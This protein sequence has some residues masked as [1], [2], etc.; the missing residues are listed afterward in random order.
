MAAVGAQL[1]T[2]LYYLN[3]NEELTWKLI[4]K[5]FERVKAFCIR[6]ETDTEPETFVKQLGT[7]IGQM[8][9]D[10]FML[11]QIRGEGEEIEMVGHMLAEVKVQ[12]GYRFVMVYHAESEDSQGLG[13]FAMNALKIWAKAKDC[14][15][16]AALTPNPERWTRLY[17][18]KPYRSLVRIDLNGEKP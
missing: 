8:S 17:G 9:P 15:H 10:L 5:F 3:Y 11:A 2:E 4:P 1:K 7:L 16:I 6:Y 14:K 18:F 12:S 13:Q